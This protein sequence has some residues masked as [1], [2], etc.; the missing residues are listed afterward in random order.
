MRLSLLLYLVGLT[1]F[2]L[3]A[4]AECAASVK[5]LNLMYG[6]DFPNR[7][8]DSLNAGIRASFA[9]RKKELGGV[10][11]VSLTGPSSY[12][13]SMESALD[14]ALR[15]SE[16]K[17]LLVVG[18]L[19]NDNVL[20][21]RD[22]LKENDLVAFSPLSFSNEV[23]GWNPNFY[24]T[25]VEP[26][27]ELLAL[28]RYV[29]V[30]MRLP[31]ISSMYVKD[32]P[33]GESSQSFTVGVLSMMGFELSSVFVAEKTDSFRTRDRGASLNLKWEQFAKTNPQAVLLFGLPGEDTQEFIMRVVSDNR[34]S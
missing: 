19:G 11:D 31:R 13:Q 22:K 20:W 9:A 3:V 8:V 18:P 15:E 23:R 6:G 1:L 30:V 4:R 25:S 2:W 14:D 12:N 29:F 7:V 21:S 26:N 24:F 33:F 16:G 27:A 10:A 28:I 5:V 32:T 34:T 17:L